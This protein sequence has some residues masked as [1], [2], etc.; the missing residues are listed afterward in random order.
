MEVKVNNDTGTGA[1]SNPSIAIGS[2]AAG[3]AVWQDGRSAPDDIYFARRDPMTGTWSANTKVNNDTG[4]ATQSIP[5]LALDGANNAYAVW[6]D[7]RNGSTNSDIYFSK[8]LASTGV[9]S[10]NVKVNDDSQTAI[11]QGPAIGVTAAGAATAVWHD[12]RQN[13]KN[14]YSSRL[15]AGGSTWA[16]NLKV[17]SNQ[18]SNKSTPDL[19]MG[20]DGTTYVVWQDDQNGNNDVY[21]ASLAP[22]A[23]AWSANSKVSDDPGT[24]RQDSPSIAVDQSG[25]LIVTWIDYRAGN[26]NTGLAEVRSTRRPAGTSIWSASVIVADATSKPKTNDLAIRPD[27]RAIAVWEDAKIGQ[28]EIRSSERDPASGAWTAPAAASDV[29][30]TDLQ[31]SVAYAATQTLLLYRN[32]GSDFGDIYARRKG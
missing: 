19:A 2:D 11:Q 29:A 6:G 26:F 22:G 7:T 20:P 14:L 23:G 1:Q 4:T 10:A 25:N 27:G 28:F 31:P 30:G 12:T 3:F 8:R 17:T 5:K 24:A 32:Q 9:W 21:F 13:K 16:A 18:T 15:A